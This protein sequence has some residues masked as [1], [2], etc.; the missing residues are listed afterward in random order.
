MQKTLTTFIMAC[1]LTIGAGPTLAQNKGTSKDYLHKQA[2]ESTPT[3]MLMRNTPHSQRGI[4]ELTNLTGVLKDIYV[5]NWGELVLLEAGNTALYNDASMRS[6]IMETPKGYLSIAG[7]VVL[8]CV[9]RKNGWF[10][11]EH[12]TENVVGWVSGNHVRMAGQT[13]ITEQ[14]QNR[15]YRFGEW[16]MMCVAVNKATGLALGYIQRRRQA[17][18]GGKPLRQMMMGKVVDGAYVFH[19]FVEVNIIRRNKEHSDAFTAVKPEGSKAFDIH[20]G[21]DWLIPKYSHLNM[22]DFQRLPAQVVEHLFGEAI[23]KA[24]PLDAQSYLFVT[25]E[26]LCKENEDWG[27]H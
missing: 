24:E 23:K 8:P 18:T 21:I 11:V 26:L 17:L 4:P 6:G 9:G 7:P 27:I 5:E 12:P 25:N 2:A 20:V 19:Y 3:E 10:A 16:E 15:M 14:Q 1:A 13:D 22:I